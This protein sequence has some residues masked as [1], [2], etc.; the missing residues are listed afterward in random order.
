MAADHM[1]GINALPR[2]SDYDAALAEAKAWRG[3]RTPEQRQAAQNKIETA[4]MDAM[5]AKNAAN[6]TKGVFGRASTLNKQIDA[7]LQKNIN[8]AVANKAK[9]G[10]TLHSEV[11]STCLEDLTWKDGIA[12]AT[13]YR[14]GA[15]VYDFP[16]EKE[17]FVDWVSSDSIGRYG[18]DNVF[19]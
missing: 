12:T 14:G 18:N 8:E 13:F 3:P 15:I 16:M 7:S 5:R 10:Q 2:V 17:D 19:D 4:R 11:P 1:K 6:P 9:K